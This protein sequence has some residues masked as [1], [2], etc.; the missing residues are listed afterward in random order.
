AKHALLEPVMDLEIEVP[1]RHLGDITGDLN[2]RRG[3]I[4]GMDQHGE[5]L[6]IRAQVPLSEI[7]TYST[8]L[9]S[10]TSGEGT[11]TMTFSRLDVVPFAVAQKHMEKF[12]KSRHPDED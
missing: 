7:Q 2:S 5:N 6:V 3:R 1:A 11:F 10:M 8:D 9:R 12:E 4:S